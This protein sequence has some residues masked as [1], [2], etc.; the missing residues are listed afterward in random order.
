MFENTEKTEYLT[1]AEIGHVRIKGSF[2]EMLMARESL[3]DQ[4]KP[5]L[6]KSRFRRRISMN[7]RLARTRPKQT[8]TNWFNKY[9]HRP[10][11]QT[12]F[13]EIKQNILV[14]NL[15]DWVITELGD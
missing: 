12:T 6:I 7:W 9:T 15:L 10:Q 3:G 14:E 4:E 5:I 2:G 11:N 13:W 1:A 8:I